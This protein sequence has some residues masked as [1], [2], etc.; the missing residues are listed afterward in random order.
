MVF[1][2]LSGYQR[3]LLQTGKNDWTAGA[4]YFQFLDFLYRSSNDGF[5]KHG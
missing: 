3:A 5:N 2:Y 4:A 1:I